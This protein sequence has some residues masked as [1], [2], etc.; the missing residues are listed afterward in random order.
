MSKQGQGF[1]FLLTLCLILVISTLFLTCLHHILLYRKSLQQQEI[2]HQG[3][4]QLERLAKLLREQSY[5][6]LDK[7]C[8]FAGDSPN[9]ILKQLL[10][11]QGC[12][13][14]AL[15]E[16]YQYRIED[17]GDFTCTHHWRLS[18]LE[19]PKEPKTASALQIR[20]IEPSTASTCTGEK[21]PLHAGISSWRYL[22]DLRELLSH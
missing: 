1:I 3:F 12:S 15:E 14:S 10:A 9:Q 11:R 2:Q 21:Q 6:S 16:N 8:A 7:H 17:L 20:F 19:L 18:L 22:P 13:L 5:Q 4:Y